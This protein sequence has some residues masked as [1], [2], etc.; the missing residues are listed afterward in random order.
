MKKSRKREIG[1]DN[2]RWIEIVK[3]REKSGEKN[4]GK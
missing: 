3:T 1:R 2:E 4:E